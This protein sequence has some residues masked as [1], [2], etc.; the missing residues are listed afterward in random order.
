MLHIFSDGNS[1]D[2]IHIWCVK[3]IFTK[4]PFA[5]LRNPAEISRNKGYLFQSHTISI[6]PSLRTLKFNKDRYTSLQKMKLMEGAGASV[7]MGDPRYKNEE[8]RLE[9]SGAEVESI[10]SLFPNRCEP[11]KYWEATVANLLERA[12][13]PSERCRSQAFVHIAAH[14]ET[15][16]TDKKPGTKQ[17]I[18]CLTESDCPDIPSS[19]SM[20]PVR[21]DGV[22]S[23]ENVVKSN[24]EWCTYMIVLSACG[25]G[26]GEVRF[27]I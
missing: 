22:L 13:L 12:K 5:A 16:S 4:V 24:I 26:K 10:A 8:R 20:P 14:C 15:D 9:K 6:T 11:L 3:Q 17:G 19:S 21:N 1:F 23:A 18:L 7:A 27:G 25:S 2:K